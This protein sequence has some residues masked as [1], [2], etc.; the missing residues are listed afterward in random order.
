[1]FSMEKNPN[2]EIKIIIIYKIYLLKTIFTLYMKE[3]L[4]I[5]QELSQL[6]HLAMAINFMHSIQSMLH[7]FYL[8]GVSASLQS[9][10]GQSQQWARRRL[11]CEK[12][13]AYRGQSQPEPGPIWSARADPT[14]YPSPSQMGQTLGQNV[15]HTIS[16][17]A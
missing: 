4:L 12:K 2:I 10:K 17:M 15:E 9:L 5:V 7:S 6:F 14:S 8:L 13:W 1:M 11:K 3:N 16:F